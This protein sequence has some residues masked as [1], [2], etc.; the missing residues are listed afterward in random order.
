MRYPEMPQILLKKHFQECRLLKNLLLEE[1]RVRRKFL[2]GQMNT[3]GIIG[4]EGYRIQDLNKRDQEI[5]KHMNYLRDDY[6][7]SFPCSLEEFT[8]FESDDTLI[9]KLQH[10][11]AQKVIKATGEWL[12]ISIAEFQISLAD[13]EGEDE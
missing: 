2:R 10:E 5:I 8:G 7:R 11:I 1:V 12:E 6:L 13:A 4:K 9:G 3:L